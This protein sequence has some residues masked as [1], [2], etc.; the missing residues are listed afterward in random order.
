MLGISYKARLYKIRQFNLDSGRT[1]RTRTAAPLVP[2]G[3]D[4]E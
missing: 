4:V 3:K 2:V 1:R